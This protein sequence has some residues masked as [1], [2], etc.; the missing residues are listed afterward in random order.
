MKRIYKKYFTTLK[1]NFSM[2][3]LVLF[4]VTPV[5]TQDI[6]THFTGFYLGNEL[7]DFDKTAVSLT[8]DAEFKEELIG[9]IDAAFKNTPGYNYL[10]QKL[11]TERHFNT[12]RPNTIFIRALLTRADIKKVEHF[13]VFEYVISTNVTFEF[14]N[15]NSGEVF[16]TRSLTSQAFEEVAKN[17]TL[18]AGLKKAY[19]KA[20]IKKAIDELALEIEKDYQPGVVKGHIVKVLNT[21]D[22]IINLGSVHKVSHG[23]SFYAYDKS[24][25]IVSL[26][27]TERPQSKICR[28]RVIASNQRR[29]PKR[30]M[31]VKYFG[32][33]T[34][35][36]ASGDQTFMVSGFSILN[37][38]SL[39]EVFS[40]DKQSLGQWLHDDLSQHSNLVMLAPLLVQKSSSVN[41]KSAKPFWEAQ[42]KYSTLSGVR[43]A[44]VVGSRAFPDILVRGIVTGVD[45]IDYITPGVNNKVLRLNLLIEFYNRKTRQ[46]VY[47]IQHFQQKVEKIVKNKGKVYRD[48]RLEK[49]F[50]ELCESAIENAVKKLPV[51]FMTQAEGVVKKPRKSTFT[52]SFSEGN[53]SVGTYVSL[54]RKIG[55]VKDLSGNKIEVLINEYGRA[56]LIKESGSDKQFKARALVRNKKTPIKD[57]DVL[58]VEDKITDRSIKNFQV[59]NWV[60][61][62]KKI[63]STY[64]HNI[65]Q[66]SEWL[67]GALTDIQPSRLLPPIQ[68]IP[69]M[70][71][72]EV[73]L[74]SGEFEPADEGEII[75][76][77]DAQP[78]VIVN[79]R[80]GLVEIRELPESNQLRKVYNLRCGVEIVF[81]TLN[82][83]TLAK[84][85]LSD[86]KVVK[87][88]FRRSGENY[89]MV[90]G[91]TNITRE[92][93]AMVL[94]I[95]GGLLRRMA[96]EE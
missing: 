9:W 59:G 21:G 35:M 19:F 49:S 85:Q 48:L 94:K 23:M 56:R 34:K 37:E 41:K 47:S 55:D 7:T 95:I 43:E 84:Q 27:K 6:Q 3:C 57:G 5:M 17:R 14:F 4:G 18:S 13:E 75:F 89:V 64:A 62:G 36:E 71:I 24:G 54:N 10:P 68:R 33:N 70:D 73:A 39:A 8:K 93:D 67:H 76:Q 60:V 65:D 82:G 1:L 26:L 29:K 58:I 69:E 15:I 12:V 72:I 88:Q 52:A 38:D 42:I 80:L 25:N 81:T 16:Y 79:A 92:F 28:A 45:L 66:L 96:N 61:R 46:Y 2:V 11:I 44:Q 31:E 91:P 22:I 20:C 32:I 77:D 30:G 78:D 63:D 51:N 90:E 50:R 83:D 87:Q 40:V 86:Q 74:L 53:L